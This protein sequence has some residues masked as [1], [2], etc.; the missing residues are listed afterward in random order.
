VIEFVINQV[1]ESLGLKMNETRLVRCNGQ[2]R[3]LSKDFIKRGKRLIHGAEI[4][5]EYYQDREFVLEINKDRKKRREL[6]TF[7][8]IELAIRHVYKTQADDLI[9]SL[10]QLITFDAIIGNNDRHF[11]NWGVIGDTTRDTNSPVTFAPIYDSARGLLWNDKETE[12]KKMY[13]QAQTDHSIIEG[14]CNRSKPRFSFLENPKGNHFELIGHLCKKE[15][16]HNTIVGLVTKE[17]EELSL[18]KLLHTVSPLFSYER[19]QLM[20]MI[21]KYRFEMLRRLT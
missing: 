6:L 17:K 4:L 21:L 2:I 13:L 9:I 10:V 20:T 14:Y 3:F 19:V 12:V 18:S 15:Q 8:E 16:Y 11:Y 7:D 1:G 5:I